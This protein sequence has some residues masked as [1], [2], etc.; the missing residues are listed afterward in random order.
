MPKT[1]SLKVKIYTCFFCLILLS[2]ILNSCKTEYANNQP[3]NILFAI[4]DDA[5]WQHFGAYGCDWV[6]TPAFD[7][8]ATQGILFNNAYTPNAKCAPSRACILTGRNSWQLEEACNHSPNFPTKFKT[9]AEALS[10]NGYWVGSVA[11]GWAPGNPGK[12][13]REKRQLTGKKFDTHKLV[14]PTEAISNNDYAKNFEAFLN[15][16]PEGKPFCFW[17]GSH[18]PHRSYVFESGTK[19][20]G[21]S[22][23]EIDEVPA[24]WP[25]V[26]TVRKDMLDYAFEIEYFDSHLQ[27][28]LD[29]LE[30]IGELGNT[31]V[32]VTADNGMPFPR[33]KGQVYEYS[34]H[35]PLAIMWGKGIKN[36]GRVIEDY[37]NFI[38]FTPTYLELAGL[39]VSEANMQPVAGR[40]LTEI[41]NSE[42]EGNIIPERNYVLVGKE[43]HDVGRPDDQGYP[44]RGIIKNNFLY[45]HNFKPGRWPKGNPE[46][47][48]LNCD[49]SP[50]K[51]YILNTRRNKGQL[52][53]WQLN[54]GK[55]VEE[56][57][58]D[59]E[60]DPYCMDNLAYDEDFAEIKASLSE[61][62]SIKLAEQSDPRILGK[63]DIFDNYV[64]SGAVQNFYKRYMAGDT[65]PTFWVNESDFEKV[66]SCL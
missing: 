46:T 62:M 33:I 38:D 26:D 23:S 36:P 14:P 51:T 25:D 34:N 28:M 45:L 10:E 7:R 37:V 16:R 66:T 52:E 56:E 29:K 30:E 50:T 42:K 41:F 60:K 22:T 54:F 1:I 43:R 39:T 32:I 64:Y 31:L 53:L 3:P 40:S 8:V 9:Y 63:G 48:Y 59:I 20:G 2:F 13:N 11:K 55:K 65:I 58:Y 19:K 44:V 5:S 61:E 21:K 15:E 57:L 4:A 6:K 17:Y 47:G 24:F 35:L 18:E 49:G 27:K 12:V